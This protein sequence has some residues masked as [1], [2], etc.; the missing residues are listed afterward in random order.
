MYILWYINYSIE[1]GDYMCDFIHLNKDLFNKLDISINTIQ[2]PKDNL[3]EVLHNAQNIFGYLPCEV[4]SYIS[5]KLNIN[6]DEINKLII[7]IHILLQNLKVN[8][9]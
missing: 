2:N 1:R 5:D 4:T 6:I 7:F 9:K 8:I 3:L